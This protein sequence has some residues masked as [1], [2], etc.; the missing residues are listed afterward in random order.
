[1][2]QV[3]ITRNNLSLTLRAIKIDREIYL[4]V[5][6]ITTLIG[7]LFFPRFIIGFGAK[8]RLE[9]ITF[10]FLFFI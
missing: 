7:L 9:D 5:L 8:I 2:A 3:A 4:I 1:M 6:S 10:F